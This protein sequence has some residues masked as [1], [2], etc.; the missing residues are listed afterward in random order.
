MI[1]T[2]TID[3]TQG[4]AQVRF[5]QTLSKGKYIQTFRGLCSKCNEF[6]DFKVLKEAYDFATNHHNKRHRL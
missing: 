4:F 1:G 2:L 3:Y 5:M 6:V